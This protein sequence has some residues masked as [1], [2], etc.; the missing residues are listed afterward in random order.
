MIVLHAS[1]D[2]DISPFTS[3]Q[4]PPK[5]LFSAFSPMQ[6]EEKIGTAKIPTVYHLTS[7]QSL[8]LFRPPSA[9]MVFPFH[10]CASPK[11]IAET[12]I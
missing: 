1:T 4:L 11:H 2:Y 10:G 9:G 5:T 6:A 12:T 7:A 3:T 8:E